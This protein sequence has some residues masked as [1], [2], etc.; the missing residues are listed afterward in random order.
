MLAEENLKHLSIFTIMINEYESIV[1]SRERNST[2]EY[3]QSKNG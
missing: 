2:T 3:E 1:N